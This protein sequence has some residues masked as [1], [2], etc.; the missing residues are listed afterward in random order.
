MMMPATDH[1]WLS[2]L[3]PGL[4]LVA[5]LLHTSCRFIRSNGPAHVGPIYL[6]FHPVPPLPNTSFCL[7]LSPHLA[8]LPVSSSPIRAWCIYLG[9]LL[10]AVCTHPSLAGPAP[11][12]YSHPQTFARLPSFHARHAFPFISHH[13]PLFP[14]SSSL[15]S[16]PLAASSPPGSTKLIFPPLADK[17]R[18]MIM[19]AHLSGVCFTSSSGDHSEDKGGGN[20]I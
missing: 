17:V 13:C 19:W 14:S 15:L 6:S 18:A 5:S 9:A 20:S 16:S 12:H 7:D 3:D 4:W 10:S 11:V 2:H 1:D 8:A